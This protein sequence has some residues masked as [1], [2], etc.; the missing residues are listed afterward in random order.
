MMRI[1]AKLG[2]VIVFH[3][4]VACASTPPAPH[5]PPPAHPHLPQLPDIA[6]PALPPPPPPPPPV[7][8]P[9]PP[10]PPKPPRKRPDAPPAVVAL[11]QRADAQISAGNLDGAVA[12]L[13]QAIRISPKQ[14]LPW[15]RLVQIKVKQGDCG[16]AA[17][18][19][20]KAD[21]LSDDP[22]LREQTEQLV[23]KCKERKT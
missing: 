2:L 3:F 19:A 5:R 12:T 21:T 1:F 16:Q 10:P 15:Y 11:V 8:P 17:Q 9:P 14:A 18:F 4:L 20:L 6:V 13:E 7:E 22:V 23:A